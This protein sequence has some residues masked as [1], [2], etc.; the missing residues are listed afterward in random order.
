MAKCLS[1]RR[2]FACF[3]LMVSSSALNAAAQ[4]KRALLIG[5]NHY[6][7]PNGDAVV[8]APG[9]HAPDSRFAP[10]R[11]WTN[12]NGPLVD[13]EAMRLLLENTYQFPEANVHLLIEKQA[14]R[15]GILDALEGLAEETK[16]N[17]LVVVYYAGHG[18]RR[19]DTASSKNGFD[20]TIVPSD[21]WK[22]V[23]DIRDKE[24][25]VS[26]NKLI[27]TK[28]ARL[29]AI[30]DS[31]H[32]GTMARGATA[33]IQRAL[34]YD[35]RD[36]SLEK[37]AILQADLKDVPQNGNAII[38]AAAS[39][40]ES[41]VEAQYAGESDYHGA[42]T[43]ALVRVLQGNSQILSAAD[44]ISAVSSLLHAD[45]DVP[46]QQPSVEGRADRSLFG[47][48]VPNRGLHARVAKVSGRT[49]SLDVGSA[50]GFDVGTE[51]TALNAN[52]MGKTAMLRVTNIDEPMRATA[53]MGNDGGPVKAGDIFEVSKMIYVRETQLSVFAPPASRMPAGKV[54]K[55]ASASFPGLRWVD[56]PTESP[57]KYLVAQDGN[58]FVAYG[59]DGKKMPAETNLVGPAFLLLG[60]TPALI[61]HIRASEAFQRG[62]FRLTDRI[63][64]NYILSAR[65]RTDGA[66]E[67]ALFDPSVLGLPPKGG[68]VRSQEDD[69][70]EKEAN[71][72]VAPEVVCRNDVSLPVRTAWLRGSTAQV[73]DTSVAPLLERRILRLGKLRLWLQS[74]ALASGF[75]NQ[76]EFPYRLRITRL[77]AEGLPA[78]PVDSVLHENE[79]YKVSIEAEPD[80][81]AQAEISPKYIYLFG[82]DCAANVFLLFPRKAELNGEAATPQPNTSGKYDP[83]VTLRGD[84]WVN[85][86]FGA[87]TL[88]LVALDQ[89]VSDLSPLFSDDAVETST[90]GTGFDLLQSKRNK[91]GSRGPGNSVQHWMLQTS[92][93]PSRP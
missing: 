75:S 22:G 2:V 20:E 60:P 74:P 12:L 89:K 40:T 23:E 31:C 54:V 59:Q 7:P 16:P 87:D 34:P 78:G 82:F 58:G 21:A 69:P 33:S 76:A 72:S 37:G 80:T 48:P 42:F 91:P 24:L 64:S 90:R 30:F 85:Q 38:L 3:V 41:A 92:V 36:A 26:F 71:G 50:A 49:V 62:A 45:N 47:E 44:V 73:D 4:A 10:G 57:V 55:A 51:F 84:L 1:H 29:T 32:S 39:S 15:R 66:L 5:I 8:I 68:W 81:L 14:T 19:L 28:Q 52:G 25:A 65:L 61:D 6:A 13:V 35:D 43:R 67:Y 18:S 9:N 17:D 79:K 88:F 86:P 53:E 56:D 83:S 93:I 70:M 63:T 46:F 27:T 11:S 77:T